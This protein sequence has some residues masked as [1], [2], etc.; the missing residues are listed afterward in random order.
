[1]FLPAPKTCSSDPVLPTIRAAPPFPTIQTSSL[2]T[3]YTHLIKAE[4]I[5]ISLS[6]YIYLY[7]SM[8]LANTPQSECFTVLGPD[9]DGNGEHIFH[10]HIKEKGK[11]HSVSQL[12]NIQAQK[13]L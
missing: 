7:I 3:K 12:R 6:I 13:N 5:Y 1:M 11:P 10:K 2:A 9:R 8:Q 4:I